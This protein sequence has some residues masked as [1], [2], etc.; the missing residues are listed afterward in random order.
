MN[1]CQL[2]KIC[3]TASEHAQQAI[4]AWIAMAIEDGET[5]PEPQQ[6]EL[7]ATA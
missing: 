6:F 3:S 2:G 1:V 5:V 7:P 4:A